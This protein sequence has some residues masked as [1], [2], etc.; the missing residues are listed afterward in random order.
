MY[1]D[2]VIPLQRFSLLSSN[3]PEAFSD[4]VVSRFGA[5]RVHSN[6][7]AG[8]RAY[9]NLLQMQGIRLAFIGVNTG[10]S[11][12]IFQV[13]QLRQR[14]ILS[15]KSETITDGR[16]D[17]RRPNDSIIAIPGENYISNFGE[18]FTQLVLTLEPSAVERKLVALLGGKPGCRLEFKERSDYARDHNH[19]LRALLT[20]LARQFDETA[21]PMPDELLR[22]LEE[23][24]LV[25]SQRKYLHVAIAKGARISSSSRCSTHRR[26]YRSQF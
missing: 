7:S 8:F 24:I 21:S 10:G 22:K 14:F 18:N 12:E 16:S 15:G 5:A 11:A 17:D 3:D 26:I 1:P 9:A 20:F 19:H 4:A 2:S 13:A 25:A 6:K 23:A